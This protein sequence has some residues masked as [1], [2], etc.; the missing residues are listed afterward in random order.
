ESRNAQQIAHADS[1][2][3]A[4]IL[5]PQRPLHMLLLCTVLLP[6]VA[7]RGRKV[8]ESAQRL[9]ARGIARPAA[10]LKRP[11]RH[12]DVR[13]ELFVHLGAHHVRAAAQIPERALHWS[14][15]STA[16]TYRRQLSAST[17]SFLRPA[18]VSA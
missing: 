4:Q 6:A 9:A 17:R 15:A 18:G 7:A 14:T 12:L 13:V 3:L 2:V 1:H 11:G 5:E 16:P 10:G 8:A